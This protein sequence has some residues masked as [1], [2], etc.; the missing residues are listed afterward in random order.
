MWLW[1]LH[2]FRCISLFFHLPTSKPMHTSRSDNQPICLRLV[3]LIPLSCASPGLSTRRSS[4]FSHLESVLEG[5][6][7]HR[8]I[9]SFRPQDQAQ[10]LIP[11]NRITAWKR[12]AV[13]T[14]KIRQVRSPRKLSGPRKA[15]RSL[16]EAPYS[17]TTALQP[18]GMLKRALRPQGRLLVK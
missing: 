4:H 3:E 17:P 11:L 13:N 2:A 8:L 14:Q 9:A 16:F 10:F 5:S 12:N 15:L 1:S 6:P 18:Q 7:S